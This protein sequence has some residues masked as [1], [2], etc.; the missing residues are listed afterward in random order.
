MRG[1]RRYTHPAFITID[2]SDPH[3]PFWT[4]HRTGE[5]LNE[6]ETL[7]KKATRYC[8]CPE[9]DS[10]YLQPICH[11]CEGKGRDSIR[12]F[13]EDDVWGICDEPDCNCISIR[14]CPVAAEEDY[15]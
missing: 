5:K 9:E 15:A 14:Y 7:Y 10:I 11:M 2:R 6:H 13:C 4:I 8:K 3:W 1:S 12:E